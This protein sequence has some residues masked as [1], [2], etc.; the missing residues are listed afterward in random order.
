MHTIIILAS[1]QFCQRRYKY[2]TKECV[3]FS[4]SSYIFVLM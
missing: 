3:T 2:L 4:M 1:A